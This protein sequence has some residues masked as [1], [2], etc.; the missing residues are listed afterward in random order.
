MK[1]PNDNKDLVLLRDFND[2]HYVAGDPSTSSASGSFT[3]DAPL[4]DIGFT[5]ASASITNVF[6]K[7]SNGCCHI[8]NKSN[9]GWE[10]SRSQSKIR[11]M[12]SEMPRTINELYMQLYM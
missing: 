9:Q 6:K 1:D 11:G 10:M 4:P 8:T 2:I 12:K 7:V 5:T 3:Q